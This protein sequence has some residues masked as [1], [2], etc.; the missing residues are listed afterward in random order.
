MK[1]LMSLFTL[2]MGL[3]IFTFAQTNITFHITSQNG[4]IFTEER[5][6]FSMSFGISGLQTD[7][8]V[9]TFQK[10]IASNSNVKIFE[11]NPTVSANGQRTS[12]LIL[13][14]KDTNKIKTLFT[15]ANVSKLI[16][17]GKEYSMNEFDKM[18]A[19]MKAK[20]QAAKTSN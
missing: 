1:K 5:A 8:D 9:K 3:S 16:V 6:T 20:R 15:S 4:K 10:T 17:D 2:F 13:L 14:D 19:D 7:N 11:V 12:R 18:I